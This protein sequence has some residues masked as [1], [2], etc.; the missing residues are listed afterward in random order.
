MNKSFVRNKYPSTGGRPWPPHSRR[1]RGWPRSTSH[2]VWRSMRGLRR[3]AGAQTT[4]LARCRNTP[5]C[6]YTLHSQPHSLATPCFAGAQSGG[7]PERSSSMAHSWSPSPN[8]R[9]S[10]DWT[11]KRSG[12]LQK[13]DGQSREYGYPVHSLKPRIDV[14][15]TGKR[16]LNGCLGG[17]KPEVPPF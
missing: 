4:A 8:P 10:K 14:L 5:V 6:H 11:T 2:M 16:C 13:T 12:A 9:P 15:K 1:P 7:N 3:R 17:G